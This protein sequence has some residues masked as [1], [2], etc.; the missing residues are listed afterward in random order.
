[1][2]DLLEQI[3]DC[4]DRAGIRTD[5]KVTDKMFDTVHEQLV[6]LA[7]DVYRDGY[8]EGFENSK[9]RAQ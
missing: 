2:S 9:R 4:L 1:M 5:E 6:K 8:A 7:C 3:Y